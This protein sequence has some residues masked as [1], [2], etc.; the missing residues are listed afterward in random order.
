MVLVRHEEECIAGGK[1]VISKAAV[2]FQS[3]KAAT[4]KLTPKQNVNSDQAVLVIVMWIWQSLGGSMLAVKLG[5][6]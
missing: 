4:F 5:H 2:S 6:T 3:P 1:W